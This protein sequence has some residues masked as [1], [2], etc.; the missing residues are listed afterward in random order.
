MYLK[1][2][3]VFTTGAYLKAQKINNKWV[4]IVIGFEDDTYEDGEVID[5]STCTDTR[6]ELFNRINGDGHIARNR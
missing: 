4:W 3:D 5:P 1:D 6:G 2:A